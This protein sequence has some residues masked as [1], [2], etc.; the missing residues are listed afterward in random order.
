MQA[1]AFHIKVHTSSNILQSKLSSLHGE[2]FLSALWPG[3]LCLLSLICLNC[4]GCRC[5]QFLAR[6]FVPGD[7]V[8]LGSAGTGLTGIV[9]AITPMRTTLRTE[10]D[11]LVTVP[12]KVTAGIGNGRCFFA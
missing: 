10:D 4:C 8:T 3:S 1:G 9:E 5:W 6:P 11:I 12:N 2:G 7:S